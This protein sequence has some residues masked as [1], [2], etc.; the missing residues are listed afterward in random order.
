MLLGYTEAIVTKGAGSEQCQ[1]AERTLPATQN[2]N[3]TPTVIC[4]T[5]LH[6][7][8]KTLKKI[9]YVTKK[10]QNAAYAKPMEKVL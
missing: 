7:F 2:I 8:K 5:G 10:T 6:I 9:K 1:G 4:R 3:L